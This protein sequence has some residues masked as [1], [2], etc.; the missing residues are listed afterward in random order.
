MTGLNR[1][2]F[3]QSL[4]A[5]AALP[6][7]P[8][9][10]PQAVAMSRPPRAEYAG[11]WA[12]VPKILSDIQLPVIPA[13]DFN[14]RDLGAQGEGEDASE[15]FAAAVEASRKA[16]GGRIVVPAG[17]YRT[18]PIHLASNT[19]LHLQEGA[20]IHFIPEPERYLPAVKTRWEGM[21]MMGYSPLI[22]A[23]Q[24]ENIALT[25]KGLIDGGADCSTWWP[26]KG[27]NTKC[28]NSTN[29]G[30][31]Q[32][33]PRGALMKD[34]EAGV[35]VAERIYAE[36]SFLRPPLVQ[37]YECDNVL[38]EGVTLE[39][40]PFWVIHPVLCSS[41][42]VRGVTT[43]S[44]G[45]NS[46]G[47]DPESCRN[48]L[49]EDCL[50]DNGDDCIAI[51]S[52]RNADGRRVNVPTENVVVR[53]CQMRD[54]HGGLV[55]GSEISGGVRN[56]FL[57]DCVMSSPHLERGLR[58]KT[59]SVRGGEIHDI[60]VRNLTIGEVKDV[61]VINFYYE[62]GDKGDFDP[63]VYNIQV[64]NLVC[65]EAKRAFQIRGFERAPIRDLQIYN[66]RID[67]ADSLGVIEEVTGLTVNNV[68]INGQPFQPG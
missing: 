14:L 49:I 55:L 57:E 67:Q 21:E 54:G 47:C 50:F 30:D 29:E 46:D 17:K 59:N 39:N 38:I 20:E 33:G 41:L 63:A 24:C 44:H 64:E 48:V 5:A 23:H 16:G 18:G 43:R 6:A 3:L 9:L 19:E 58:I 45:P 7:V 34:V 61:I 65:K 36:G 56:V 27:K 8:G 2:V 11:P 4:A 15:A 40:S 22:Y 25:G 26:W 62:E 12:R 28:D 1:R 60:Y 52:G 13:R 66:S 51:K 37:F 42:T 35:P 32:H 68:S 10:L 53:N 31:T